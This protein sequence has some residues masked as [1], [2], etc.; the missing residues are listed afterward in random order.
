MIERLTTGLSHLCIF[1]YL[2]YNFKNNFDIYIILKAI[3]AKPVLIPLIFPFLAKNKWV[4]R[5]KIIP[6]D[7]R[8]GK[9]ATISE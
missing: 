9:A 3:A 6:D 8:I 2:L 1:N 7:R 4:E 5:A